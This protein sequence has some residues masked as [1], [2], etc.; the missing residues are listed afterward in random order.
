[1]FHQGARSTGGDLDGSFTPKIDALLTQFGE[2]TQQRMGAL[3]LR[4]AMVRSTLQCSLVIILDEKTLWVTAQ[5]TSSMPTTLYLD[6][7]TNVFPLEEVLSAAKWEFGFDDPFVVPFPADLLEAESTSRASA[8]EAIS[9]AHVQSEINRVHAQMNV[10]PINPVF[11]PASYAVDPRLTFVLMPFTDELTEIYQTFIKPV[12]E[13][14]EFSLVCRR[15]DDVKSNRAI[16]QDIWKSLCEARFVIADLTGFNANVLYELGIAHTLGKE[17]ILI[18]Q[19]GAEVKFPFDLSHIRRIEYDNNALGGKA[20]E[21]ELRATLKSVID[22]TV[23][24]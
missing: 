9:Q 17:T 23:R 15:A 6:R 13:S 4:R 10:V 12:V 3:G 8:L 22:A 16:I 7:R 1:M 21:T 2:I 24:A 14:P 5:K 20:L 19:R 18:Y 11:G